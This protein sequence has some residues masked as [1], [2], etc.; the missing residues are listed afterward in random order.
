MMTGRR[1]SFDH[2]D[3]YE[4]RRN[5]GS[6]GPKKDL[7]RSS[8]N[9]DRRHDINRSGSYRDLSR[10]KDDQPPST[11]TDT[12]P[13]LPSTTTATMHQAGLA[14]SPPYRE[15]DI[16][17]L[18]DIF[19]DKVWWLVQ[20]E[21]ERK[22]E[23]KL[24]AD[25]ERCPPGNPETIHYSDILRLQIE[26]CQ[27]AKKKCS[28]RM[29]VADDKLVAG[30]VHLMERYAPRNQTPPAPGDGAMQKE[31]I[32]ATLESFRG[33]LHASVNQR[34]EQEVEKLSASTQ[35]QLQRETEELKKSLE[36]ERQRN[37]RLEKRL[38]DMEQK[39]T[40]LS[41]RQDIF[42]RENAFDQASKDMAEASIKLKQVF[43]TLDRVS[44]NAVTKG[45]L[46]TALEKFDDAVATR[47]NSATTDVSSTPGSKTALRLQQL[48]STLDDIK[49]GLGHDAG[50]AAP[51]CILHLQ[52][53]VS[54][55][56]EL[57]QDQ[58]K[59]SATMS[60]TIKTLRG[61]ISSLQSAKHSA[62]VPSPAP[63]TAPP[64]STSHLVSQEDLDIKITRLSTSLVE[65]IKGMMQEKLATV[66]K[67]LGSFID[68][69]RREREKSSTKA[70]ESCAQV[71]SLRQ[72]VD[73]LRTYTHTS[74]HRLDK[75]DRHHLMQMQLHRDTMASFDSRLQLLAMEH[76]G[77][78]E[79]VALQLRVLNKWQSNF[80]TKPMYREIVDHITKTLPT[81]TIRQLSALSTRI[82]AV[83]S[84]MRTSSDGTLK[85]RKTQ[86]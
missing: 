51:P 58:S 22:K 65:D 20:C 29:N 31:D 11:T 77:S 17:S 35:S 72:G 76:A 42:A 70:Q 39:F 63:A 66:A 43:A 4:D 60:E 25:R 1:R 55:G 26:Q 9:Y 52:N 16:R 14:Y 79:E 53:Q 40:S 21:Q 8:Y 23:K 57:I 68:N 15:P 59:K 33:T 54:S 49:F 75:M 69:E 85:K 10:F 2:D 18:I 12:H 61:S 48:S 34:I 44:V 73:E 64:Q 41:Q 7:R 36:S 50:S 82:D 56:A 37:D 67:E 84:Q 62:Q 86:G 6:H 46:S 47:L 83:E 38:E 28:D 45:E 5:P 24:L 80:T 3:R 74:V 19:C 13:S 78:A 81:G 32:D 30:I 71:E 27:K